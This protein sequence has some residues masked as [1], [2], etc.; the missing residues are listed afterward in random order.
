MCEISIIVP[1][2]KVEEYL[3]KCVDSILA[4]TFTDIEVILVDDGSPDRSGVICDEYA[5]KDP[6]VKVIHKENGG[7]SSARNAGIEVAKGRYLGFV[8]S[9]DYIGPDMYQLL[10]EDITREQADLAIC[11]IVDLYGNNVRKTK[12]VVRK[13]LSKEAAMQAVLE[14]KLVSVHAVNKL[15]DSHLFSQIRYPEGIITEDAAVILDILD[16]CS[17]VVINTQPSYFY[18][19]RDES[20]SSKAFTPRDIDTIDVWA[21]NERWLNENYPELSELAHTRVCW[22]H[23]VVLDKIMLLENYRKN[24]YLSQITEYLKSNFGFIVHSDIFLMQRKFALVCLVA[25]VRLYKMLS[26]I[27]GKIVTKKNE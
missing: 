10:Y 27:H 12:P 23:F 4:Q 16:L 9:D 18:Y 22:A 13:I 14:A 26:H 5:A 15:Y 24:P 6:R 7:L 11:G 17:K 21:K 20:I 3:E 25:N 2:Y 1:V 19:H 8:D